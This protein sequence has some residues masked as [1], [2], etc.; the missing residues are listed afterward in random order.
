VKTEKESECEVDITLGAASHGHSYK[1][2]K[3]ADRYDSYGDLKVA[4]KRILKLRPAA[5]D[6]SRKDTTPGTSFPNDNVTPIKEPPSMFLQ[7]RGHVMSLTAVLDEIHRPIVIDLTLLSSSDASSSPLSSLGDEPT[8]PQAAD[9]TSTDEPMVE[10]IEDSIAVS[11]QSLGSLP[12]S[13]D[14]N[15]DENRE[16]NDGSPV[17]EQPAVTWSPPGLESSL[18][19]ASR[20]RPASSSSAS[21]AHPESSLTGST[22]RRRPKKR[23]RRRK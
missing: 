8:L 6:G 12:I 17:T 15:E 10:H 5:Q 22:P 4:R 3:P 19:A 14:E 2:F 23:R 9:I 13:L 21:A 1:T 18:P 7:N 20:T 16:G 11:T